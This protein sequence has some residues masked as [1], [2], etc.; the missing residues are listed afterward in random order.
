M[1]A[2]KDF[3]NDINQEEEFAKEFIYI[4][5]SVP[6][7]KEQTIFTSESFNRIFSAGFISFDCGKAK[8]IT[9]RFYN[10][11]WQINSS[12]QVFQDSR[13]AFMQEFN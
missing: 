5:F 6:Q 7:G 8:F 11:D 4:E 1:S 2:K 9:V 10:E 3:M 13:I 12:M